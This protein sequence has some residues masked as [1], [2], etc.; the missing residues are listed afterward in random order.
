MKLNESKIMLWLEFHLH[1][2]YLVI[3]TPHHWTKINRRKEHSFS[4]DYLTITIWFIWSILQSRSLEVIA[5]TIQYSTSSSVI[6]MTTYLNKKQ[7]FKKSKKQAKRTC[8]TLSVSLM[9]EYG[10]SPV[11]L[12]L[13]SSNDINFIFVMQSSWTR[14][15][16]P[17]IRI[18]RKLWMF[19]N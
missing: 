1:G 13:R 2:I 19:K 3:F 12:E 10:I 14:P 4:N 17:V 9:T 18:W 7:Q 8:I 6:C 11:S 16:D 5:L 15:V